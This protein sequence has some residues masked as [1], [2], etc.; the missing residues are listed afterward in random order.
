MHPRSKKMIEQRAFRLHPLVR[1]LPPFGFLDYNRLQRGAMCVVSDS[2]TLP[3]EA[4]FF[5]FAAVCIRTSTERPESL[6]KG[7]F[8]LGGITERELINAVRMAVD[9]KSN[10][11]AGADVPD[12]ADG[13]VSMKVVQII[14]GYTG[15]VDRVVWG[16]R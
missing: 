5:K 6:E 1:A 3:E 11:E 4:N 15:I 2:G 10:G 13:N 16:K 8:V 9:M 12:Y 14:E 7:N